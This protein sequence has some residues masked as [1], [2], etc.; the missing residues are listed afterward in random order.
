ML[1]Y[2]SPRFLRS[3]RRP[4]GKKHKLAHDVLFPFNDGAITS[5][6]L[7]ASVQDADVLTDDQIESVTPR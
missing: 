4:S 7:F 1:H 5:E 6:E 3:S 2:C